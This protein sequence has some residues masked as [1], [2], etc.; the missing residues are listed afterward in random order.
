MFT[1]QSLLLRVHSFLSTI[2][3][4]FLSF[5]LSNFHTLF[6]F[7]Y[8]HVHF[9]FHCNFSFHLS[10][11]LWHFFFLFSLLIMEGMLT[12]ILVIYQLAFVNWWMIGMICRALFKIFTRD[13]L[14]MEALT[15]PYLFKTVHS[16]L[17]LGLSILIFLLSN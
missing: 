14:G 9:C 5:L 16:P 15:Q 10:F 7:C 12:F 1:F 11:S 4:T 6:S 13:K 3:L 8:P 17:W 2:S